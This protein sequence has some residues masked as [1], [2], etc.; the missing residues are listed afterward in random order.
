MLVGWF[1]WAIQPH[2][3]ARLQFNATLDNKVAEIID[4]L[5]GA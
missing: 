2:P 3:T 1:V 5:S 4:Q